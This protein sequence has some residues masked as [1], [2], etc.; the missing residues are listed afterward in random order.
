MLCFDSAPPSPPSLG[1]YYWY[2]A[3]NM[4]CKG[5]GGG[6][7]GISCELRY[8]GPRDKAFSDPTEHYRLGGDTL[9][10]LAYPLIRWVILSTYE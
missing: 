10:Y 8:F 5:H 2:E 1:G 4:P 7:H 9:N 3:D 6:W